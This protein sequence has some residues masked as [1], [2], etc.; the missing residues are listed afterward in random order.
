MNLSN[1]V[2]HPSEA[3]EFMLNTIMQSREQLGIT[4]Q[5]FTKLQYLLADFIR[6]FAPVREKMEL[7]Q[8]DIQ[9]KF[10]KVGKEPTPEYGEHAAELQ[11]QVAA[12]QTQFSEQALKNVLEPKQRTKLEELLHGERRSAPNG[13]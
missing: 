5:Q 4:P 3:Q 10:A 1:A 8:L 11:K 13:G 2:G 12:L 7:L 9:D 6:A